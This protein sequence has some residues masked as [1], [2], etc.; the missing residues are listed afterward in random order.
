[1]IATN[2]TGTSNSTGETVIDP[3]GTE[4]DLKTIDNDFFRGLT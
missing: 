2:T 3:T 4:V 1:M